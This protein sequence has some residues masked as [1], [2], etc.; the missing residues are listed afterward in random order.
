MSVIEDFDFPSVNRSMMMITVKQ[1]YVDW[2]NSL[3]DRS[4]DE[5]KHPHKI[6][7]LNE[8]PICYL[9]PEIAMYD[10]FEAYIEHAWIMLFELQLSGWTTDNKLW[11]QLRT[12]KMFNDWF[13]VRC[14][15]LILDLWGKDQLDYNE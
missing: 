9:I 2:A 5:K 7:S 13:D 15:S 14:S 4:A 3:P 1:P 10:D 11:P 12:L 8:D 6:E